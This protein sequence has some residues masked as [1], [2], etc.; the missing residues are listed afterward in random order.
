MDDANKTRFG[1]FADLY[2]TARPRPP[3]S[4]ATAILDYWRSG[5]L[6]DRLPVVADL[7]AGTGLSSLPWLGN[8]ARLVSIE[9]DERMIATLRERIADAGPA[10]SVAEAVVGAADAIPL[11]DGAVDIVTAS[12]S[13]HWMN[14]R[15]AVPEIER[16]L[17]PGGLFVAYDCDWPV[18]VCPRVDRAFELL[19]LGL[20]EIEGVDRGTHYPKAQHVENLEKYGEFLFACEAGHQNRE[21]CDR[22]RYLGI[23][24]SQGHYQERLAAAP[25]KVEPLRR[26]FEAVVDEEFAGGPRTMWVN[27]RLRMGAKAR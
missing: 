5:A 17:A 11:G 10:A 21:E 16:V 14:P 4:L 12:Q 1:A 6:G 19:F 18:L 7:G 24:Y 8:V 26:A 23:A 27:Y 15:T 13:F 2:D 20:A 25:A 3:E 9:P 22:D